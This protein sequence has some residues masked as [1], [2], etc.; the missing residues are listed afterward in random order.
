MQ[1]NAKCFIRLKK[2]IYEEI[3][4][5][6]LKEKRKKYST[7]KKKKFIKIDDVLLEVLKKDYEIMEYEEQRQKYLDRVAKKMNLV[8]YDNETQDGTEYKNVILNSTDNIEVSF[9]RKIEIEKLRLVLL[10]LNEEEYKLIKALFFENK[11]LREYAEK[12][13]ISH[14]AIYLRKQQILKKIEKTFKKLKFLL[15]KPLIFSQE[16]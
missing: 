5:K 14:V 11:T 10:Q 7:Y 3:T 12:V 13:G 9:E 15:N 8:S 4:Y 6:E 1:D 2:G 16:K